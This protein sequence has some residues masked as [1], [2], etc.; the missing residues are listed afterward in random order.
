[1]QGKKHY[2]EKLFSSFQLSSRVP[3]NNFYR[4]L[5]EVLDLSILYKL[6]KTYYGDCGQKNILLFL[7]FA[8][9]PEP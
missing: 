3:E 2:Q 1:M 4:R 9:C 5:R 8:S 7:T 6:T